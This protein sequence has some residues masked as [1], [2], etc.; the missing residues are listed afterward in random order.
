M[1]KINYY[2]NQDHEMHPYTGFSYANIESLP[3]LNALRIEPDFQ[4]CFCP[5]E[6]NGAWVNVR[7]YR[8]VTAYDKETVSR[9]VINDVGELPDNLTTIAPTVEFPTWNGKTWMTDKQKKK[10]SDIAVAD[11]RKQYLIAEVYAETQMLQTKL[12]LGRISV[13]ETARL[14]AWLDHLELLESV[15]TSRDPNNINWPNR[16]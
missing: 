9:V 12:A 14:N 11:E 3:P 10:E 8:G 5:C 15:D 16:P 6:K 2:Y 7:D 13:D 1:E 4:E